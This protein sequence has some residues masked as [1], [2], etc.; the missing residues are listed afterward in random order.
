M[1]CI[2]SVSVIS[3]PALYS[4]DNTTALFSTIYFFAFP[5]INI[6]GSDL[7]GTVLN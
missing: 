3:H 7:Y 2:N 4:I 6:I 1:N 5:C